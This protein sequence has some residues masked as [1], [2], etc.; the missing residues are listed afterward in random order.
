MPKPFSRREAVLL[1]LL[2]AVGISLLFAGPLFG[3]RSVLSVRTDDPRFDMRPWA[4]GDARLQSPINPIAP[5]IDAFT[6]PG[7]MRARQLEQSDGS[8]FWDPSQLLGYP[9]AA[10]IPWPVSGVQTWLVPRALESLTGRAFDPVDLMDVQLALH[11]GLA[12]LLAYR[13]CRKLRCEPAFAAVGA[14]GFAFC[15]WTSTRWHAPQIVFTTVWWPAQYTALI[16]MRQG[17]VR[18]G[19]LEGAAVTGLMVLS[20]FPQVGLILTLLTLGLGL[21]DPALLKLRRLAA[22]ALMAL[23]GLGLA[24][25]QLALSSGA[26]EQ[27]LRNDPGVQAS[28]AAR[29]LPAESLLGALLPQAFGS[30]PD[31]S[32]PDAPAATMEEW[33]PQRLWWS[34]EIQNSVVENALY[35][36]LMLL[37]LLVV[38][39]RRGVDGRARA[40]ALAGIVTVAGAILAPY[41]VERVPALSRL[42]AGNVKRALVIVGATLPLAGA[43]ALQ[44]LS[45][46]RRR[47]PWVWAALLAALL[48]AAPVA[49]LGIDDDAA[50]RWAAML[51][52]QSLRQLVVL[53]AALGALWLVARLGRWLPGGAGDDD[54]PLDADGFPPGP[55]ISSLT[56]WRLKDLVAVGRLARWLPALVLAADLVPLSLAFNPFPRQV[57]P[58][59]STP[60]LQALA[61]RPGRVVLYG[62]NPSLLLPTAAAL[63]GVSSLAGI[64]PMVPARSAELMAC[65]EGSLFDLRDPRVGAPLKRR[66]SLTHPLLDLL[67]VHTVVHADPELPG[68]TGWETVFA[69]EHE[70]L[71]ALARPAAGPRAFW[72]GGARL[73]PDP[74]ERLAL[75]AARDFD[76]H[77]TVLVEQPLTASLPERSPTPALPVSV[78]GGATALRLEVQAPGPGL[79][80]LTDS[81]DPG[82]SATLDGAPVPVLR[83]HHALRAVEV[84]AGAHLIEF[85]YAPPGY[86]LALGV[87]WGCLGLLGVLALSV[88]RDVLAKRGAA[89]TGGA[90]PSAAGGGEGSGGDPG[91]GDGS[92]GSGG[93]GPAGGASTRARRDRWAHLPEGFEPPA[94]PRVVAELGAFQHESVTVI[95]PAYDDTPQ[96][97]RAIWSIRS[98]ADMPFQLVVACARQSVAKNRNLGLSRARC[99]LI[100]FMDD[101]VL[102]P[103]GWT[104]R[105][106]SL[107]AARDDLGA[108]SAHLTFS[109]GSPQTRRSDLAPGEFWQITI[110]GTCF[111]FSRQRITGAFFDEN[112]LGSQWEDT[113]FMWQLHKQ[114]LV[115]GVTGDV[116]VVHDHN[117]AENKWLQQNGEYFHGKWGSWPSEDDTFSISPEGYA[118]YRPTSLPGAEVAADE[119]A[120]ADGPREWDERASDQD[121]GEHG[122]GA[123]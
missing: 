6:L 45:G 104:S 109:D 24:A 102:L 74:A 113:D 86:A 56:A 59:A 65:I 3:D 50:P 20:G 89:A 38:A 111:C 47:L 37:V 55:H 79:V 87:A 1:L 66:E 71:G 63:H 13:A 14:I 26:Y 21:L 53:A 29:G 19:L 67:A 18:R 41:A 90:D 34:H 60:S 85:S 108:V 22:L 25:P 94:M 100:F 48:L 36:G 99:D 51:L 61:A 88:L 30:P 35:P 49:A 28:N 82:W 23:L 27:S 80:V 116:C 78:E 95:I 5:D 44:A 114:G 110:P 57:Q 16:W 106:L 42:A 81:W 105:M 97:R 96:L 120:A 58:F 112:Y 103:P 43:L 122:T 91:S 115:T 84:T 75:L 46:G 69:N 62:E 93:S 40:L 76:G 70:N 12:L 123:G 52:R 54:P 72:S 7:M 33:L 117:D 39:L 15:A 17:F 31:F 32:M 8:A 64:A 101:D 119:G 98:T 77:A 83:A 68:A 118:A 4:T 10:N 92:G 11:I 9:L 73:V 2:V 121:A 107:L